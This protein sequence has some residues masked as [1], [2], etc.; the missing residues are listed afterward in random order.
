M[1]YLDPMFQHREKTALVMKEMRLFR[2][3]VGM[4]RVP[5]LLRRRWLWPVIGGQA[6][7]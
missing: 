2:P 1:I 3:L 6:A 4:I 7:A 5:A